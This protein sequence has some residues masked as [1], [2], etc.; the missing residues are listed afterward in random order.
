MWSTWYLTNRGVCEG[1]K[2]NKT[3]IVFWK[4]EAINTACSAAE[5][6][7]DGVNSCFWLWTKCHLCLLS[8]V[9]QYCMESD[10]YG[11]RMSSVSQETDERTS[12]GRRQKQTKAQTQIH[13]C[14][15]WKEKI[16]ST[17]FLCGS[18]GEIIS[19]F[20]SSTVKSTGISVR[21]H[22]C[23]LKMTAHTLMCAY[24]YKEP[25]KS[26]RKCKLIMINEK[27]FY[28]IRMIIII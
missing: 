26:M 11:E 20:Y 14:R 9:A 23:F 25:S 4:K 3:S 21:F 6:I 16:R 5:N 13:S 15:K 28:L 1:E 22:L 18:P 8:F 10:L 27:L 17:L 2:S 7:T 19:F 24:I 12:T